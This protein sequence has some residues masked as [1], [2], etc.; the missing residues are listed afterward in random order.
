LDVLR[1]RFWCRALEIEH[2]TL[3]APARGKVEARLAQFGGLGEIEHEAPGG[4][5]KRPI[6]QA[7]HKAR[8]GD[9]AAGYSPL[10]TG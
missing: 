5:I 4:G 3:A 6:A 7:R 9:L 1:E 2:Q 8:G 10:H